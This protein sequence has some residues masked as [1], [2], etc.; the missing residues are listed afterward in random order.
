MWK[1]CEDFYKGKLPSP[2]ENKYCDRRWIPGASVKETPQKTDQEK[3]KS[4]NGHLAMR[5]L[6]SNINIGKGEPSSWL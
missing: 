5:A 2:Q 1:A 3:N 6:N 4:K